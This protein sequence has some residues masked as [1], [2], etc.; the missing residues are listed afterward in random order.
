MF[1]VVVKFIDGSP[2]GR[3]NSSKSRTTT[4][5]AGTELVKISL[6]ILDERLNTLN[7]VELYQY[8]IMSQ[9]TSVKIDENHS[10]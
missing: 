6:S 3:L 2:A 10:I 8:V 5:S 7:H 4:P 9:L 1:N